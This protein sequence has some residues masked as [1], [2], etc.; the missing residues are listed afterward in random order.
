LEYKPIF[1]QTYLT[2][3]RQ[4]NENRY[5]F[6]PTR[7]PE[8]QQLY[9]NRLGKNILDKCNGENTIEDIL[10]ELLQKYGVEEKVLNRDVESFMHN[11]WRLGLLTWKNNMYPYENFY[12]NCKY[13]YRL[14]D[15]NRVISYID[16]L[17]KEEISY[18]NPYIKISDFLEKDYIRSGELSYKLLMFRMEESGITIAV[19]YKPEFPNLFCLDFIEIQEILKDK[20][21]LKLFFDWSLKK[22][23]TLLGLSTK[24][25]HLLFYVPNRMD[26][27]KNL[28]LEKIRIG[29]LKQEV[30]FQEISEDIDVYLAAYPISQIRF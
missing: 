10:V 7:F 28:N 17:R 9:I 16:N 23:C 6:S 1:K 2:Y 22:Y 26:F 15:Y 24:N 27:S 21:D 12:T 14:L 3:L 29:T 13:G 5:S 11:A 18:I 4:E 25:K 20:M 19:S 8:L 30:I